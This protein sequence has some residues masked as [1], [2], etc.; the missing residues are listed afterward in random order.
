M[1]FFYKYLQS[2]V[3]KAI[4]QDDKK[5]KKGIIPQ[6]TSSAFS[7]DFGNLDALSEILDEIESFSKEIDSKTEVVKIENENLE[8]MDVSAGVT[9]VGTEED[10][11]IIEK[12]QKDQ[13][14]KIS[15]EA[16]WN[17]TEKWWNKNAD[18]KIPLPKEADKENLENLKNEDSDEEETAQIVQSEF[19]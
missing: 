6:I 16:E 8:K 19:Q 10:E 12:S 18:Q 2:I 11:K 4:K 9:A 3:E 13:N 1:S 17:E 5:R 15:E 14:P 7:T